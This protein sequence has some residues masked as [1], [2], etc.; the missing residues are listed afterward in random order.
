LA[1]HSHDDFGLALAGQFAA[2]E[3]GADILEG[4]VNGLGERAGIPNLAA[5][6]AT[7]EVLY[8]YD[9]GI[10]MTALQDLSDFVRDVWKQPV[11]ERYPVVGR[12]AFSHAVGVHYVQSEWAFNA[13]K[14]GVVG[15]D[16]YVPLCMFSGP[17]AMKKKSRDLQLGTLDDAQAEAVFQLVRKE[18]A[19]RKAVLGDKLFADL[20]HEVL[21]TAGA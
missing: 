2:M 8:G 16:A 5:L 12:N 10:D 4:C 17:L 6:V 1:I 9:T 13:W 21:A 7:L 11:P 18:M 14:P 3:G 15:N 19:L 20:V